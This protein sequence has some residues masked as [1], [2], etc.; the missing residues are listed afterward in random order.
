MTDGQFELFIIVLGFGLFAI[1]S[2]VFRISKYFDRK[3]EKEIEKELDEELE[4]EFD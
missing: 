1:A 2:A 4:K 3:L